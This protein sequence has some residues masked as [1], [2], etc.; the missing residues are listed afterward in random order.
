MTI[1]K[2][3]GMKNYINIVLLLLLFIIQCNQAS[4]PNDTA[5]FEEVSNFFRD[6]T[7]NPY[8]PQATEA[9]KWDTIHIAALQAK[10]YRALTGKRICESSKTILMDKHHKKYKWYSDIPELYRTGEK[11]N[12]YQNSDRIA[13]G[14]VNEFLSDNH[15]PCKDLV[16]A[17][18]KMIA[19]NY[20]TKMPRK[21]F[22][23]SAE[24][25]LQRKALNDT[26]LPLLKIIEEGGEDIVLKKMKLFNQKLDT[27]ITNYDIH[28]IYSYEQIVSYRVICDDKTQKAF[29]VSRILDPSI[30]DKETVV[31]KY[32]K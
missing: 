30:G 21:D 16:P 1:Y 2:H 4:M 28:R 17:V 23:T 7:Y 29:L 24:L 27:I 10:M 12:D 9:I 11:G 8:C 6:T 3:N 18:Y 20:R 15:C 13:E 31:H 19:F 25:A 26:I 5:D 32:L 14:V 22:F